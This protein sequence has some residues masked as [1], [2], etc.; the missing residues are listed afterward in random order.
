MSERRVALSEL[1]DGGDFARRHIGPD[2]AQIVAMLEAVGAKS[3]DDLIDQAA[4]AT[5]RTGRPLALPPPI[6]ERR[7]NV[8][9]AHERLVDLA[10]LR[11]ASADA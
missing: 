7:R 9:A 1:E 4:P 2:G 10:R 5:I 8:L 3:L 11:I 6:S